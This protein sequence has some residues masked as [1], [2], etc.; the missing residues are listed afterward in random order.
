ML[1][2]AFSLL[3]LRHVKEEA[4]PPTSAAK[5]FRL[6]HALMIALVIAAVLL[7]SEGLRQLFGQGG[8]LVGATIA[9]LG[10]LHAAAAGIASLVA[11]GGLELATARWGVVALLASA[12]LAKSILAFASGGPR[13]G[14][15]VSVG[16]AAMVAG[17]A[18]TTWLVP[19]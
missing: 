2:L 17:A 13:Y 12:S 15:A 10:E 3:G 14:V 11:S 9:A 1:L 5:A 18:A 7:V 19:G 4:L 8:A 16:L 6:G